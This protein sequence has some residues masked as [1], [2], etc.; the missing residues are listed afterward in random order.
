MATRVIGAKELADDIETMRKL[1]EK[2]ELITKQLDRSMT[3]FAPVRTGHLKSTTYHKENIA[4]AKADY[5]GWVE[6]M[7]GE[8]AYATDA[9]KDFNMDKYADQVVEPF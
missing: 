6:E 7:G 8:Y 5:A 3:R 2:P 9:I 4:G 1:L